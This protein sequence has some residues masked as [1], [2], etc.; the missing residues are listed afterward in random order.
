MEFNSENE[1]SVIFYLNC[2]WIVISITFRRF[3]EN[4]LGI[5]LRRVIFLKRN[6]SEL[7]F[8]FQDSIEKMNQK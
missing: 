2:V 7:W 5:C 8:Y 1:K 6:A 4:L 3:L